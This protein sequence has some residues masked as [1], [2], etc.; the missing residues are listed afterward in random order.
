MSYSSAY[1]DYPKFLIIGE[2]GEHPFKRIPQVQTWF[3]VSSYDALKDFAHLVNVYRTKLRTNSVQ[4][5]NHAKHVEAMICSVKHVVLVGRVAQLKYSK[6]NPA[7]LWHTDSLMGLPHPLGLKGLDAATIA[8]YVH[9]V[10]K[11]WGYR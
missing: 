8:K 9:D 4:E 5:A 1:H 7:Q 10:L 11:Q 6:Y 2:A 3:G